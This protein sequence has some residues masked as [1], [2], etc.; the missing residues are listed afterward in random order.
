M[1]AVLVFDL[2][3]NRI[4]KLDAKASGSAEGPSAWPCQAGSLL[5]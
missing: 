2:N 1:D 5:S 4:G 3:G